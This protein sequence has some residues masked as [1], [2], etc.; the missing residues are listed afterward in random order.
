MAIFTEFETNS[1]KLT[2]KEIAQQLGFSDS[3]IRRYRDK[4]NMPSAYRRKSTE[5]N[6]ISSQD[7]PIIVRGGNCETENEIFFW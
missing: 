4:I 5:R 3:T 2:Q 7:G 6:K 1:P